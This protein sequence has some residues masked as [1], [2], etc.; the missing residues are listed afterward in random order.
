MYFGRGIVL[1]RT[2]SKGNLRTT[3]QGAVLHWWSNK[4]RTCILWTFN[5]WHMPSHAQ[6][7]RTM[8]NQRTCLGTLH[9]RHVRCAGIS[10]HLRTIGHQ[11][12]PWARQA[13]HIWHTNRTT[14]HLRTILDDWSHWTRHHS[15]AAMH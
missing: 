5:H 9:K 2:A 13:G 4:L 3:H 15:W 6:V 14:L 10:V 11:W 12:S 7:G 1:V 8:L